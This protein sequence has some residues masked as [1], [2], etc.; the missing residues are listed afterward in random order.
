MW[1][2]LD[3]SVAVAALLNPDGWTARQTNR[4]DITW[5]APDFLLDELTAY[6][7]EFAGK[8]GARSD[9]WLDRAHRFVER[10][11]AIPGE[12]I[13]CH[14]DHELVQRAGQID[15]DDTAYV[16]ALVA[17]GAEFLW[18]RDKA[19]LSELAPVAIRVPP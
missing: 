16:A 8:A 15:P 4:Q 3:A 7:E 17:V 12:E 5:F 11:D 9:I 14:V 13:A 18:T 19:L 6:A 10:I 1:I 2:V